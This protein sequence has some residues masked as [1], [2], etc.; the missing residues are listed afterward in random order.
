MAAVP[1]FISTDLL[2][3]PLAK[4]AIEMPRKSKNDTKPWNPLW[5]DFT[6]SEREQILS[7]VANRD[8]DW[9]SLITGFTDQEVKFSISYSAHH[10]S[11]YATITP[12][13]EKVRQYTGYTIR[14]QSLD[15]IAD[16]CLYFL[17]HYVAD[18]FVNYQGA[19]DYDW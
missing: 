3:Y 7:Y 6:K 16:I 13:S 18:G 14:H 8:V 12:K 2:C 11:F 10:D 1:S 9:T 15:R 4:G 19:D 17:D 5:V